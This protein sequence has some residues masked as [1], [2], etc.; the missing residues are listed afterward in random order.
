MERKGKLSACLESATWG[1]VNDKLYKQRHYF[2][3]S[4][5]L[6]PSDTDVHT[7]NGGLVVFFFFPPRCICSWDLDRCSHAWRAQLCSAMCKVKWLPRGVQ[8][9]VYLHAG[10]Y[11]CLQWL[12]RCRNTYARSPH[13]NGA[14]VLSD[15]L[16]CCS[17]RSSQP[18]G[19]RK[20]RNA[21]PR[22]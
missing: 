5:F 2:S 12:T 16:F 18:N 15:I 14:V 9:I 13:A 3:T 1:G 21:G 22:D 17:A 20:R 19:Q 6:S 10:D 4:I 7:S 8:T 11:C